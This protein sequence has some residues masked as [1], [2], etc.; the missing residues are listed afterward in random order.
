MTMSRFLLA[1]C[2]VFASAACGD[3][4]GGDTPP[5]APSG[6]TVELVAGGAHLTWRDNS[7]NEAHFMVMRKEEGVDS[8][9]GVIATL[10]FNS[11]QYHDAP[12]TSGAT[13]W[14]MV[15]AM[16]GAGEA[17]SN[18]VSFTAP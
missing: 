13:Y 12:L 14:Y 11:T 5:A 8:E 3:E 17:A 7:D 18:E 2:L 10:E 4:H 9:H 6:L 15:I 1:S 16:N